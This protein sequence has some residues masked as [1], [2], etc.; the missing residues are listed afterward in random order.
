VAEG[1]NNF[2]NWCMPYEASWIPGDW[3]EYKKAENQKLYKIAGHK[4]VKNGY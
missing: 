1:E 4:E 3:N 2:Q